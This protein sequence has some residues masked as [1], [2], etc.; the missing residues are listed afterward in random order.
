MIRFLRKI[1]KKKHKN[2]NK[3]FKYIEK[4]TMCDKCNFFEECDGFLFEVTTLLDDR[5]HFIKSCDN[6]KKIIYENYWKD[7]Q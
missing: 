1:F 4:D 7:V 5:Q 2:N 3:E 6:C